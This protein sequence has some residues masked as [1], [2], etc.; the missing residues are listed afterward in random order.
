MSMIGN[1]AY[2]AP[3]CEIS[4]P[5]IRIGNED[6]ESHAAPVGEIGNQR[7]KV[8]VDSGGTPECAIGNQMSKIGILE[9]T[10]PECEI[11]NQ[12]S[13]NGNKDS[14]A[15]PVGEIGYHVSTIG[16]K[17]LKAT[18]CEIGNQQ[19]KIGKDIRKKRKNRTVSKREIGNQQSTIDHEDSGCA[20]ECEIGNMASTIGHTP[21]YEIGNQQSKIGNEA[22]CAAPECACANTQC[23][24]GQSTIGNL[25]CTSP[26]REIGNHQSKIG[27][28][29][30]NA[31]GTIGNEASTS[32]PECEIE[33]EHYYIGSECAYDDDDDGSA[34]EDEDVA[35]NKRDILV[36]LATACGWGEVK[37]HVRH[38]RRRGNGWQGCATFTS[39]AETVTGVRAG[40]KQ[41]ALQ[42]VLDRACRWAVVEAQELMQRQSI[43]KD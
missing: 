35:S 2:K 6:E 19:S 22:S 3:E 8:N 37:L 5:Q 30:S 41:E 26:E 12:Q 33:A 16:H 1:V 31:A 36:Q 20:P 18:E 28:E 4:H 32:A 27:N 39:L 7:I 34:S 25:V 23:E 15:A 14:Y 13:R 21:V 10:A 24:I 11:G 9:S 40:T 42:N 38:A 29:E 43:R 17:G